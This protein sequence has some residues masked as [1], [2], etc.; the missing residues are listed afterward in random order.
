MANVATGTVFYRKTAAA[1]APEV[2]TL[3]TLKTD[4]GLTGTNSGDQTITLTGDITGSGAGSFAA[5]LATV[6]G[7][8]GSFGSASQVP[9]YTVNAKGLTTAAANVAIS[10]A[11]TAIND[12]TTAGRA[13]LT[14]ATA[15][16]QTALLDVATTTT[17]GLVPAPSTAT[18]KVL[19]DAM[20]W[21][22]VSGG[23]S[24]FLDGAFRVQNTADNTKQLAFSVSGFTTATTRTI[25][26][27]D[28]TDTMVTLTATQTLTNKT[29]GNTNTIA[30]K[31]GSFTVQDSTDTT[32]QF[33]LNI[34]GFTTAVTRTWIVPNTIGGDTFAGLGTAQTFS[35]TQTFSGATNTFSNSTIASTTNLATGANGSG[36]TKTVN[37]GTSGAA[38][39]TTTIIIGALLGTVTVAARGTW[40]FNSAMVITP[41]AVAS[42]PSAATAGNGA[43]HH[44]TDALTPTF[45]ATVAGGGAVSTPVYSDGT[46]WK[47]G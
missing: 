13:M 22:T 40:T 31:S 24:T 47:V 8:V 41:V 20:T 29:I 2:Q 28:I 9:T 21:I 32:K 16:A 25:T 5:T 11:S 27:P 37:I 4:L 19:S 6:N 34:S 12:S 26:V 38:G 3:A 18:G 36:I 17:K 30:I 39:S 14:A 10:I 23:G 1:G 46:N 33:T 43:R 45:G 44:V 15:T 42:L 7:N 35:A